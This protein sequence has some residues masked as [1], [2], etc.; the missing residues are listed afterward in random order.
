MSFF[1]KRKKESLEKW[2]TPGL[3]EGEEKMSLQHLVAPEST[4][5]LRKKKGIKE[6]MRAC[7]VDKG[8]N[9]KIPL[10]ANARTI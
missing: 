2:L 9:L 8:A 5:V 1:N 7:Q 10:M 6:K 4:E 3:K